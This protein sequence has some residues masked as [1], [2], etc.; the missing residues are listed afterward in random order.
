MNE[1]LEKENIE[2]MIYEIRGVQVMIDYD[3]ARLY[4]C[5]NGTK[6]INQAVKRHIN[7][8]P[9]RYM[10][11][12]TKDEF[13]NICG[14][15]LGPQINKIRSLPY[16]FTEQ[17]VAMLATILRTKVAEEVSIRIMDAFVEMRKYINNNLIEQK[18]ASNS[19]YR[20]Q[21]GV[22]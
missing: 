11:Q 20:S 18:I 14:P 12:L 1:I 21:L 3:L 9:E 6:T 5:S 16:A 22:N 15:N 7:K 13:K 2:N 17:G 4:Q 8:F 19:F 10:F